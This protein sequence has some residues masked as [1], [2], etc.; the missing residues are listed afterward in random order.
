MTDTSFF[1]RERPL[2]DR[3]I[4]PRT[5]R[6]VEIPWLSERFKNEA[7]ILEIIANNTNIPVPKVISFGQNS[8]GLWFLETT[9]VQGAVRA[10]MIDGRCWMPQDHKPA[11]QGTC[12]S[13]MAIAEYNIKEFIQNEVLPALRSLQYKST[14]ISGIMIPPY[15][16]LAYDKRPEWAVKTSNRPEFIIVHGDLGPHNIMLHQLTL[17][18]LAVIDWEHACPLP[19]AFQLWSA[20]DEKWSLICKQEEFIRGLITMIE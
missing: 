2:N 15:W 7:T 6:P 12:N 18:P 11:Q 3:D 5:G 9:L 10:D 1:K 19:P 16:V 17:K 4:D 14:G 8:E 20:T 13:C